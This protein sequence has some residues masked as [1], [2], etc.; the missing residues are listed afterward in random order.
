M[1]GK[2][3]AIMSVSF[4]RSDEQVCCDEGYADEMSRLVADATRDIQASFSIVLDPS[5]RPS[6]PNGVN[7]GTERFAGERESVTAIP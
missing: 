7:R 6:P 2:P 1:F 4:E 3:C 5:P